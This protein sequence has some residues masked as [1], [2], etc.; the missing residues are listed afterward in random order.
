[1]PE[2][3]DGKKARDCR[4][5]SGF[6]CHWHAALYKKRCNSK[7]FSRFGLAKLGCH[8]LLGKHIRA[9]QKKRLVIGVK[10]NFSPASGP[11]IARGPPV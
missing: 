6:F 1:M 11:K 5:L 4:G 2:L 3:F 9:V 8:A 7:K 10:I